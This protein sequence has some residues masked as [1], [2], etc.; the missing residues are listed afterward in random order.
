ME[1]EVKRVEFA[2]LSLSLSLSNTPVSFVSP[3][4]PVA[5]VAMVR[6]DSILTNRFCSAPCRLARLHQRTLRM[7]QENEYMHRDDKGSFS[8]RVQ[9]IFDFSFIRYAARLK[10]SRERDTVGRDSSSIH[11]PSECFPTY[12]RFMRIA[13]NGFFF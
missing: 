11:P 8:C 10:F 1:Q 12:E 9:L 4:V 5:N 2:S 3:V 6:N 13:L 7:Y